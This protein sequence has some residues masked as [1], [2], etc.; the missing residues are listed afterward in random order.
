MRVHTG[1][2][3]PK[4]QNHNSNNGQYER[5]YLLPSH[6]KAQERATVNMAGADANKTTG[7]E[8]F[9]QKCFSQHKFQNPEKVKDVEEFN[10]QCS[11]WWY[12][13]SDQDRQR[14]EETANQINQQQQNN[15]PTYTLNNGIL[16]QTATTSNNTGE[17]MA[18]FSY[19]YNG[20]VI[21]NNGLVIN[22]STSTNPQVVQQTS[23]NQKT[24][25]GSGGGKKASDI[26]DICNKK[27][28]YYIF[29]QEETQKLRLQNPNLSIV[30]V[31]K[32]LTARW[33]RLDPTEKMVYEFRHQDLRS[34][35]KP[36]GKAQ[37]HATTYQ[38]PRPVYKSQKRRRDPNA[39]KQPLTAFFIYSTE[40]RPK[41]K[42]DHPTM[43]VTDVAK[44]LGRRWSELDSETKQRFHARADE[45]RQKF[46]LEMAAYKQSAHQY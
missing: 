37:G 10:K 28:G 20:Q 42:E 24:G 30:E 15:Q 19:D 33:N 34:A 5:G 25:R 11:V 45:L 4:K 12:N 3:P 40:E 26:P 8:V 23:S 9:V 16:Q 43:S 35:Q 18:T 13:L 2:K 36:R 32:E 38:K 46:D 21:D 22:Y 7:Y 14:F 29:A 31:A 1:E 41:V 39:P 6:V 27:S 17:Q 44:E